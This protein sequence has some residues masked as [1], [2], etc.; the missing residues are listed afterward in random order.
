MSIF[1]SHFLSNKNINNKNNHQ[2]QHIPSN[3]FHVC[4]DALQKV[5]ADPQPR[6]WRTH[7]WTGVA[8]FRMKVCISFHPGK[9]LGMRQTRKNMETYGNNLHE[10]PKIPKTNTYVSVFQISKQNETNFD[11]EQHSSSCPGSTADVGSSKCRFGGKAVWID[12]PHNKIVKTFNPC[13]CIL[14]QIFSWAKTLKNMLWLEKILQQNHCSP[15]S[16]NAIPDTSLATAS[17]CFSAQVETAGKL[18]PSPAGN[19]SCCL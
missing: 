6:T 11:W 10:R 5:L 1:L 17:P 9:V 19:R 8:G 15:I 4:N 16:W 7:R 12:W 3:R 13:F 14:S 18:S 2:T